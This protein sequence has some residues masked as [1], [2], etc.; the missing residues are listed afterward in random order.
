M[1]LIKTERGWGGHF[2]CAYDCRFRRNTL[3]EYGDVRIVISTVGNYVFKEKTDIIGHERYYET[4]AFHAKL[5]EIYWDA[6]V[7]R[8]VDF[9]SQWA[10]RQI[11]I[12]SDQEANDM[13][14]AVVKEISNNLT[15]GE[16]DAIQSNSTTV[17][18]QSR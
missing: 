5:D 7:Q 11:G 17:N 18:R 12:Y 10:V 9:E 4:M 13:H 6:D 14:E 16:G 15:E 1:E 8:E 3:L 2:I